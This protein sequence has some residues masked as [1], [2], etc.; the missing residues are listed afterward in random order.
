MVYFAGTES[1]LHSSDFMER[2]MGLAHRVIIEL[3][4]SFL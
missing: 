3:M 4:E 1:D 2:A